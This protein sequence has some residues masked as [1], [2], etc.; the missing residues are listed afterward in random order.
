M[1]LCVQ[2]V[3]EQENSDQAKI[4]QIDNY[5]YTYIDQF[6]KLIAVILKSGVNFNKDELLERIC[7]TYIIVLTKHH[8][9]A[10][11]NPRPFFKFMFNLIYDIQ[12]PEYSLE[13]S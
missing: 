1:D 10:N 11:F 12:R 5:D 9:S 2:K 3:I 4:L 8:E 7:D 13:K 6:S